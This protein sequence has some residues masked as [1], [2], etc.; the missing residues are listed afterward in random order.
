MR[1][2]PDAWSGFII[3]SNLLNEEGEILPTIDCIQ[4]WTA[5]AYFACMHACV[6][7][8]YTV[9]QKYKLMLYLTLNVPS[10]HNDFPRLHT[11]IL[12]ILRQFLAFAVTFRSCTVNSFAVQLRNVTGKARNCL[13]RH[14][15]QS[16]GEE[17]HWEDQ[18]HLMSSTASF[19]TSGPPYI[20]TKQTNALNVLLRNVTANARNCLRMHEI[21]VWR[22]PPS[23]CITKG[24]DIQKTASSLELEYCCLGPRLFSI[25][26]R[27]VVTMYVVITRRLSDQ[28]VCAW[29][30]LNSKWQSISK[31]SSWDDIFLKRRSLHA[32]VHVNLMRQLYV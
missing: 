11:E 2:P 15:F 17:S 10:L 16:E 19:C 4:H 25:V 26:K 22:P 3:N 21:S 24:W 20:W 32:K 28:I 12:C 31:G 8:T 23:P 14:A 5:Q 1:N 18:E 6:L 29:P 13:W 30:Y 27:R 9:A 7:F